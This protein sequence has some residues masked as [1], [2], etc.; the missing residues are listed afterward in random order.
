MKNC[1]FVCLLLLLG[2][3]TGGGGADDD[4]ENTEH[5][6]SDQVNTINRAEDVETL[7]DDAS[8]RQRRQIDEQMQ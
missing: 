7:L 6:W 5:V 4:T 1:L 8:T 2:G 3:C